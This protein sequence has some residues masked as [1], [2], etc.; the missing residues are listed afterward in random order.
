M[1]P[2][3]RGPAPA[4]RRRISRIFRE[5]WRAPRVHPTMA[6]RESRAGVMPPQGQCQIGMRCP[7]Q[8]WREMHQSRIFASQSVKILRW[9]S[10]A[11]LIRP[12]STAADRSVGQRP[13]LAKPL[14]RDARLDHGFASIA[15][16]HRERMI[17]HFDEQSLRFQIGH[18]ALARLEAI[19]PGVGPAAALIFPSSVI[20]SICGSLCRRP[21]SKSLGS[22]AGVTFT[23]PV[24]NSRST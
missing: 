6:T 8:S 24:P 4:S 7:H 10:G 15:N 1:C 2:A 19:Q 18:H 12:C 23:A 14:R 17:V 11:I 5:G 9:L 3:R 22:C 16:P 20:T 21:I 13:H